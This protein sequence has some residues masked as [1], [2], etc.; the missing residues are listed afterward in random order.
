MR[1]CLNSNKIPTQK[2]YTI[3]SSWN[4]DSRLGIKRNKQTLQD[5][6]VLRMAGPVQVNVFPPWRAHC[7]RQPPVTARLIA[8]LGKICKRSNQASLLYRYIAM[9]PTWIKHLGFYPAVKCW[10]VLTFMSLF[11]PLLI[12]INQ[13]FVL[14][15]QM[16]RLVPRQLC[17]HCSV[18]IF[19]FFSNKVLYL[20]LD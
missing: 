16:V 3:Q 2:F 19:I 12:L 17:I 13:N 4:K 14:A 11:S 9:G 7:A 8:I 6:L 10:L 18:A 15:M 1:L 5:A 20:A